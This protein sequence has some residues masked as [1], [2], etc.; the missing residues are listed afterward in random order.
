MGLPLLAEA[1][2]AIHHR[3]LPLVGG[4][5]CGAR[6]GFGVGG[7]G[8]CVVDPVTELDLHITAEVEQAMVGLERIDGRRL[9]HV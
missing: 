9:I 4:H 6:G 2:D 5:R 1:V 8:L 7:T 3:L